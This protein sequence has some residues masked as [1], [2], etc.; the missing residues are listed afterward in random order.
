MLPN[1]AGIRDFSKCRINAENA[2]NFSFRT[3]KIHCCVKLNGDFP[4]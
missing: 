3:F 4:P 1:C 2:I